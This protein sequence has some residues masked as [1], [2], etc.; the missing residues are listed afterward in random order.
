MKL[1]RLGCEVSSFANSGISS[2][3]SD[4][5]GSGPGLQI[6][7]CGQVCFPRSSAG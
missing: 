2:P 1:R 5:P 7:E 3:Y 6:D 4:D